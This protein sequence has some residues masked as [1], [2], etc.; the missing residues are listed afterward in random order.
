MQNRYLLDTNI[1]IYSINSGLEL[2]EASYYI[3]RIS[4]DEIFSYEKM[5]EQEAISIKKILDKIEV[6]DTNNVIEHNT[7]QIQKKYEL[8]E[9]DSTICATAH[10]YSLTLITNDKALHKVTE[11]ETE[12][13]YF[14]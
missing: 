10:T 6:L 1:I 14:S 5:S 3:S 7:S 9:P 11:I 13:F 2:P 8:S 4:Y 12:L